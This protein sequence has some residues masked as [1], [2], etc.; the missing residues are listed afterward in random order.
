MF[1]HKCG[2]WMVAHRYANHVNGMRVIENESRQVL[3]INIKIMLI[4]FFFSGNKREE[5][6]V[7]MVE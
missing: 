1:C 2:K 4:F 5:G 6:E 7:V 3:Q